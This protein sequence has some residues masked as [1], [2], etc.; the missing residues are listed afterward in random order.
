MIDVVSVTRL[1]WLEMTHRFSTNLQVIDFFTSSCVK[2][3]D[4]LL[5]LKSS[6]FISIRFLLSYASGC[7][8]QQWHCEWCSEDVDYASRQW[9]LATGV[10]SSW[11][12]S[13]LLEP[14]VND[15]M[16]ILTFD[17]IWVEISGEA[18]RFLSK[19]SFV[20]FVKEES[21]S[22]FW[23]KSLT[24]KSTVGTGSPFF[25]FGSL[26][27]FVRQS[28]KWTV[29]PECWS[30]DQLSMIHFFDVSSWVFPAWEIFWLSPPN[31]FGRETW[32]RQRKRPPP[33][34]KMFPF[35]YLIWVVVSNIFYFQPYLGKWSN[36]TNIFQMGGNQQLVIY[37]WY[38]P[39][40]EIFVTIWIACWE[41]KDQGEVGWGALFLG[42]V[43]GNLHQWDSGGYIYI[44]VHIYICTYIYKWIYKLYTYT[45]SP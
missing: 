19:H 15:H 30:V 18:S 8:S 31:F 35:F 42:R 13:W 4:I 9:A 24:L 7:K 32:I 41:R 11:E 43:F 44:Y 5:K 6:H 21:T 38:N 26:R 16:N 12:F 14:N 39:I 28:Y 10:T 25:W 34:A 33:P 27:S 45:A 29:G 20:E 22:L 17:E 23:V 37:L 2:F 1:E 40:G 36:V 3:M